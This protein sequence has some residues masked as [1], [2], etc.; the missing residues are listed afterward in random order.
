MEARDAK[1][2]ETPLESGIKS[3]KQDSYP[4]GSSTQHEWRIEKNRL[5]G[6]LGDLLGQS[7]IANPIPFWTNG[8]YFIF[9]F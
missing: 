4:Q 6:D 3:R 7:P 8:F 9:L 1:E 2:M 5:G